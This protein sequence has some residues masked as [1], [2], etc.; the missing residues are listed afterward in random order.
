MIKKSFRD[1]SGQIRYK[2]VIYIIGWVFIIFCVLPKGL[3]KGSVSVVY[4][5]VY[6]QWIR[7]NNDKK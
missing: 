4:I 6:K 1:L 3:M 2:L 5:V 7:D